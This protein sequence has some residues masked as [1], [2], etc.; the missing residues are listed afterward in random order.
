MCSA[1]EKITR[2]HSQFPIE[3][4]SGE[5]KKLL[6]DFVFDT[7]IGTFGFSFSDFNF[8][9][10]LRAH[11]LYKILAPKL[12]SCVLGLKLEKSWQKMT[13]IQKMRV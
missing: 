10:I 11:F 7:Y 1:E 6:T 9:N 12:Q 8:I 4:F 5:K 13:F 2:M 3:V